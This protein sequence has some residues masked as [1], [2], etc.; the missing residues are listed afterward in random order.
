MKNLQK[1][2]NGAN[3]AFSKIWILIILVIL[4]AGGILVCPPKFLK[5]K[6]ERVWQYF[7]IP[8]KEEPEIKL[9]EEVS[10]EMIEKNLAGIINKALP[11]NFDRKNLKYF[12]DDLNN[13]GWLEVIITAG[14]PTDQPQYYG[15]AYL[16]IL[17]VLNKEGEYKKIADLEF[18]EPVTLFRA[19]PK[20][21]E[22]DDLEGLQDIDGD[23][24]KEIILDL[25]TGG[26]SNEAYGI[27]DIDWSEEKINWLNMRY[28]NGLVQSTF[29]LRGGS[30]MHQETFQLDD[31]DRDGRLE[32]IEKRGGFIGGLV[33]EE[34]WLKEENWEWQKR[35]YKWD[36]SVFSYNREL[37]E[38][39]K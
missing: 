12:I 20:V 2:S 28:Q 5:E 23:G 37:S 1:I 35:V 8:E 30:V 21:A 31:L 25:G 33:N 34:N 18:G 13:D 14:L 17:K 29:L 10:R 7:K 6:F 39:L 11:L 4:V 26:A 36:G 19:V 15:K 16:A 38:Q 24:Q 32:I 27:F 9:P 3:Q 22:L